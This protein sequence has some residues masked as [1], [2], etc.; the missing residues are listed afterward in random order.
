MRYHRGLTAHVA[1][2][3]FLGAGGAQARDGSDGV[4]ENFSIFLFLFIG[5]IA[6]GAVIMLPIA[7]LRWQGLPLELQPRERCMW[8]T[9]PSSKMSAANLV[10]MSKIKTDTL[11]S[12]KNALR[13][14]VL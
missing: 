14:G 12:K 6:L 10:L 5:G 8:E 11:D 13:A 2:S 7:C 3:V 9:A 1:L 4:M